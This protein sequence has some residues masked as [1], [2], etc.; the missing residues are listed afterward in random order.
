M[1]FVCCECVVRMCRKQLLSL[2]YVYVHATTPMY[3]KSMCATS[4]TPYTQHT[5]YTH[6]THT[7]HTPYPP[8]THHT[9]KTHHTGWFPHSCAAA[10]AS[11][12][13]MLSDAPN[14]RNAG[15]LVSLTCVFSIRRRLDSTLAMSYKRLIL[16][17]AR[18]SSS[19]VLLY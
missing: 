3:T 16:V 14:H 7:I 5:P 19:P 8:H 11:A 10:A 6:H 15:F 13:S 2:H 18:T 4:Y 9:H 1:C 12:P 17:F